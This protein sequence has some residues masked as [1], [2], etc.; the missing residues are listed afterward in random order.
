[1]RAKDI[2]DTKA[3]KKNLKAYK[4]EKKAL[5]IELKNRMK[6]VKAVKKQ[7]KAE[8]HLAN[9]VMKAGG[10]LTDAFEVCKM[11]TVSRVNGSSQVRS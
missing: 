2:I 6:A 1:M 8:E 5:A 11:V 7:Q 9:A 4:E 10:T 3:V